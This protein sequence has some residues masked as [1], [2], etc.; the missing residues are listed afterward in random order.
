M[1]AYVPSTR[2][3]LATSNLL[4]GNAFCAVL[5]DGRVILWGDEQRGADPKASEVRGV[6]RVVGGYSAFAAILEDGT[7][8]GL[9]PDDVK[10]WR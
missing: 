6:K 5:D 10:P 1:V 8:L 4:L 2:W 3:C 7:A 9:H